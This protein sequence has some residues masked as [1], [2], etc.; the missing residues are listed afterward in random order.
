M[1]IRGEAH[2][3]TEGLLAAYAAGFFP[4]AESKNGLI[5]W[6]SPDPRC[7]LPLVEFRVP[8]SLRK[9]IDRSVFSITVDQRFPSVIQL[10]ADRSETW[11]SDEIVRAYT[12]LHEQ[13]FAHS[14]EAWLK[15]ELVGGLYGVA[16]RG[17]FFGESMFTRVSDA[18]KVCLVFLVRHLIERGYTLLDSQIINDHVRQFGAVEVSREEYLRLLATALEYDASF[19]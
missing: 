17:A 9:V 15:G 13:G 5:S 14:V 2:L 8:R 12:V 6:F 18:S 4:M 1:A 7:I 16:I 10:C 11:I 19:W 3:S